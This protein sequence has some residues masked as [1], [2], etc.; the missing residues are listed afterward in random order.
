MAS[1]SRPLVSV[2]IVNYKGASDTATCLEACRTLDWPSDELEL[3]VVDNASGDGSVDLLRGRFPDVK[4]VAST[5][6]LGF[7]GGCNRGADAARGEYVAFLN[8]DARPDPAWIRA[9]VTRMETDST[10]SCVASKILDWEGTTIDFVDSALSFYGHG[11]KLHSEKRDT[12]DY[13][14]EKDVLFAS[15]AAMFVRT[16]IFRALGGFDERYFM[17]FEDVDFGWRLW[18][19][20]HRAR[21]LPGSVVYHRHHASMARYGVWREQFLLERNALYTILKNYDDDNLPAALAGALALAIRRGRINGGDDPTVLDLQASP[22]DRG[23]ETLAVSKQTMASAYAIDAF[24]E[25]L[26]SLL[27]SRRAL[28]G[29]R[30]RADR[31]IMRLFH[32]PFQANCGGTFASDVDAVVDAL[33]LRE[34]FDGRRRIVVATGDSLTAKMAGP[35]IRAWEIAKALSLEHDVELVTLQRCEVT[36]ERFRARHVEEGDMR[37]LEKWCDVFLFQGFLLA[38]FP[39]MR[40]SKKVIVV[41]VYDPFHL[42]QLEQARD[43]EEDE[44]RE[45]IRGTTGV[46]NDQL[47]RGDFFLCASTKQ[48]DFWLG[49]LA[50][51]G[52]VNPLTYDEDETLESLITVVPFGVADSKPVHRQQSIKGV[53]PGIDPDDKVILWGGGVYN[54]FDPLT[55]LRAVD[56]LRHRRP[57]VRLFFL[58]L[59]HPNPDVPE[60]R[61][62]NTMRELADELGLTGTHVFFNEGWVAYEDR[63]NYLL[64]ADVGVS[65]H[66][67]HVETAFSFRTRILDYLWA[68]LP[69]VATAGD[70]LA[71]LIEGKGLGV[72]VPAGDVEALEEALFRVIDDEEF[73]ALCRKNIEVV[74]SEFRWANVLRPLLEFCRQPRRAP[75]VAAEPKDLAPELGV[76]VQAGHRRRRTSRLRSEW[77]LARNYQA[78]GGGSLVV[79]RVLR[80]LSKYIIGER[81]ARRAF[82]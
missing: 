80:R 41:D 15:G 2:I 53:V 39:F 22:D 68:G 34:R 62:A 57:D 18:L 14:V 48:R 73:A 67:D 69:I 9:A 71:D 31:E 74:A 30:Q 79:K 29:A 50:G 36:H 42:E 76:R 82:G 28:Q 5:K 25:A 60:M 58:G 56:R 63:A 10:I 55:L 4:V 77:E 6:N 75:D 47:E 8:N 21:F 78:M 54:W 1:E 37:K 7:A 49:Q 66:L 52:R 12:G 20:G 16:D 38:V 51:V 27:A 61:M 44:R 65:T 13:D 24:V 35:A 19:L 81:L 17:F 59:K 32:L 11:F 33:G 70:A 43:L 23:G 40:D 72:T 45:V 3:I 26:P 46:L 64:E